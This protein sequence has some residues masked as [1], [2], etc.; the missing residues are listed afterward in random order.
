MRMY[1]ALALVAASLVLNAALLVYNIIMI[2]R[3]LRLDGI[4][5]GLILSS[6]RLSRWPQIAAFSTLCP[7]DK[8]IA[9]ELSFVDREEAGESLLPL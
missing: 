1:I 4:L 9:V 8:V 6:L 7:R 5:T 3:L 2:R